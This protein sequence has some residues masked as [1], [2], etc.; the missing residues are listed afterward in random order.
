MPGHTESTRARR[1]ELLLFKPATLRSLIL[2]HEL[3]PA[4]PD[5]A[6]FTNT[7]LVT[8]I[9]TA[10]E[11]G[12]SAASLTRHVFVCR[13]SFPAAEKEFRAAFGTSLIAGRTTALIGVASRE[14]RR[15]ACCS[16]GMCQFAGY[17]PGRTRALDAR[18]DT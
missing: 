13:E 18:T 8:F 2:T 11:A 10:I 12:A 3:N 15:Y 17:L 5:L 14:H 7:Q 4:G 1:R 16:S 9:V 6:T